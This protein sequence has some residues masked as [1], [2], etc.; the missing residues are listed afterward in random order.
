[1]GLNRPRAH[2]LD[3][4]RWASAKA[5]ALAD[6]AGRAT[7]SQPDRVKVREGS[8]SMVQLTQPMG[9]VGSGLCVRYAAARTPGYRRRSKSL[10]ANR[11]G[12]P[13]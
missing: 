7:D 5:H 12:A 4:S 8:D 6:L 1:M 2:C 3:P 10:R 11:P 13:L 9:A